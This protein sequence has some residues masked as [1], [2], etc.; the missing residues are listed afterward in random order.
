MLGKYIIYPTKHVCIDAL[1]S[2]LER[3]VNAGASLVG[4]DLGSQLVPGCPY[5][6]QT[7]GG[8]FN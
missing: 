4:I 3:R 5:N 8:G 7:I 6:D 2:N 1:P